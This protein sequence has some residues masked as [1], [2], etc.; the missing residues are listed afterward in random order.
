MKNSLNKYFNRSFPFLKQFT[1][2]FVASLFP[3]NFFQ[4]NLSKNEHIEPGIYTLFT[5]SQYSANA[6][7]PVRSIEPAYRQ[8][9]DEVVRTYMEEVNKI[10]RNMGRFLEYR[11][12]LYGYYKYEPRQGMNYIL[13]LFLIYRRYIGKKMSVSFQLFT[14]I[15]SVFL[16]NHFGIVIQ[17]LEIQIEM[18]SLK[19]HDLVRFLL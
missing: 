15:F 17:R 10:S 13:D 4:R 9:F 7:L 14:Q 2:P 18:S 3:S 5:A 19:R 8:C 16:R 1:K 6:E 12:T 11:K